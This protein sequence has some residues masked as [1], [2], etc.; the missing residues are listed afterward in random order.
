MTQY[1][2]GEIRC[3]VSVPRGPSISCSTTL[4]LR[5]AI[6]ASKSSNKNNEI[7]SRPKSCPRTINLSKTI[8]KVNGLSNP[9]LQTNG[10]NVT[11]DKKRSSSF[12]KLSPKTKE[13][14]VD[15]IKLLKTD[16]CVRKSMEYFSNCTNAKKEI[17]NGKY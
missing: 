5:P 10:L 11:E 9:N 7:K 16:K 3:I 15:S 2:C 14:S 8:P 6:N 17:N 12:S 13:S 4:R 1:D